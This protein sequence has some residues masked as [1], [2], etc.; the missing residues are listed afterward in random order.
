MMSSRLLRRWAYA[1]AIW[2]IPKIVI[3]A[4]DYTHL[5]SGIRCLHLLC[6]RLNR[7]GVSAAVKIFRST[8]RFGPI[9]AEAERRFI[10]RLDL[11]LGFSG[12]ETNSL[13]ENCRRFAA[14]VET[15]HDAS[16]AR[17]N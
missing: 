6:D 7:L 5:S 14:T 13:I 8:A 9:D 11:S 15:H 17:K 10:A 3:D 16:G 2:R 12:A 1:C 4:P